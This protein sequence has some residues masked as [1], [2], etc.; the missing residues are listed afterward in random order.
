MLSAACVTARKAQIGV[1][2]VCVIGL[3]TFTAMEV[4]NKTPLSAATK[5]SVCSVTRW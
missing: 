3:C 1:D 5:C 4:F 2:K